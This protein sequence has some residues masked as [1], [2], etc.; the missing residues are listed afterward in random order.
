[1]PAG[2][3]VAEDGRATFVAVKEHGWHRMGFVSPVELNVQ[4]AL[5]KAH[6]ADLDY[7]LEPIGVPVGEPPR[8][9]DGGNYRALVRRNPFDAEQWDVLGAGMTD[10]FV[11][12]TPEDF[13]Q[14]G[15]DI[16]EVGQ[17]LAA[18][19]SL[20]GGKRAFAAFHLEDVTIAGVDQVRMFLNVMTAFDGSM[21][22]VARVSAIRVV[23]SNTFAAVM[24]ERSVPTYRVRHT[25]DG[26][27]GRVDEARLALGVGWKGMAQFQAEIDALVDREVTDAEFQKVVAALYPM[28]EEATERQ[29]ST[30]AEVRS[31]VSNLYDGPTVAN[32]RGTAWGVLNAATEYA[33]WTSG[34]FKSAEA[35]MQA[36]IT[37][38][39][40]ID[41][42]RLRAGSI[43]ADTLKIKVPVLS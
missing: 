7:H 36:Q 6:L 3:E 11:V 35:R 41:D 2:I 9:I 28:P 27:R 23:C 31:V 32:V 43:V 26:L 29:K 42:R 12:H 25:G 24:S 4:T 33:D 15:Q 22:T 40:T 21:S 39:S 8:F 5:K 16:I 19:G 34:K 10:S 37:P 17:P 14:F 1:M 20:N 18:L 38:G 30:I 13:A